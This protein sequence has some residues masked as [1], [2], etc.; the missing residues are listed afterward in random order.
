MF[1]AACWSA[2]AARELTTIGDASPRDLAVFKDQ[3]QAG[4]W[5]LWEIVVSGDRKGFLIWSVE[6]EGKEFSLVVNAA[7]ARPVAGVD[8]T[9]AMLAAF[10]ALA[11]ETGAYAVRCWTA[12]AGLKRKLERAG[13]K[14]RYVME[15]EI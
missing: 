1:R 11:Q 13:C 9:A 7:A 10:R 4:E 6:Q 8:V 12:R 5:Q 2:A 15:L 14:A 3:V